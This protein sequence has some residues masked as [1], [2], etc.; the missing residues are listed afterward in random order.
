MSRPLQRKWAF[1]LWRITF[2]PYAGYMEFS[3]K[4]MD[5][6]FGKLVNISIPKITY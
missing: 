1:I 2:T 3:D 6:E 4:D 5:H